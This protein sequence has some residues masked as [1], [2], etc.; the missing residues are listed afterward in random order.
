MEPLD[1]K[2]L[3]ELLRTWEAPSAPPSLKR[4]IFRPRKSW[5]RWL[6]SGTIR[7]PVPVGLAVVVLIGLWIYSWKPLAT[8]SV[9][10]PAEPVSLVDFKPVQQLEPVIVVGG[11][12]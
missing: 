2:E 4:R 1:E 8:P 5:W 12:Q 7:V 11:Q 3:N 9:T 10:K 6:W